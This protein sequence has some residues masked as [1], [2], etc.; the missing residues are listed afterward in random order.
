MMEVIIWLTGGVREVG[1]DQFDLI[2]LFL[3]AIDTSVMPPPGAGI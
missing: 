2:G 3:P 1:P